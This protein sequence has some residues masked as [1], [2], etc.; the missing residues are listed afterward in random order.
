MRLQDLPAALLDLSATHCRRQRAV[1]D[2]PQG[3]EVVVDGRSYVS[4]ASNDY[5]GLA[6]HPALVR[7]AQQ[8][9][10]RWGVGGGSSHLLAGHF[11]VQQQA[12]EALA[13]FVGQPAALLFGSG[14]AANLAIVSSLLGRGDAVFADR[15]NHASLND[16]CRLSRAEF[17]RFH[18]N[19]LTQLERL[20]AE[21]SARS[22]LI[23]VESVYSMDGDEAPLPALLALAERYDAWLYVDDAHG[24]G[25]LGDGRGALAEHGLS[26]PRLIYMAT[27]GKAAGVA[28]AFISGGADLVEWLINSAR[29][30]IYTTS[31]PP[32]LACAILASLRLISEADERRARLRESIETVKSGLSEFK[33]SVGASRTPIQPLI[34]GSEEQALAMAARLRE[35]GLWVPAIRPP[36]VAAGTARLRLSLSAMHQP[37]HLQ[38]L[39][40]CIQRAAAS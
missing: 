36:T 21:S 29:S 19:D 8:G 17:K 39:L 14:Y 9:L 40:S 18:H 33:Y 10:E 35:Q 20:L 32:A 31:Q 22:K 38:R 6:D 5:L 2:S 15:L 7:A 34:I 11:S 16:A 24:F 27:L 28:G 30:Y 3:V 1:I 12:E 26:S 4:F 13:E 23:A 25:V 37:E